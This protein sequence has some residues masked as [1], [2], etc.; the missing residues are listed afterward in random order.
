MRTLSGAEIA[1]LSGAL[2]RVTPR[3][4]VENGS[5]TM[6]DMTSWVERAA[7][8][9]DID[10]PVSGATIDFRRD[11]GTLSL[12][13]TRAD[14]LLNR[15]DAA[16]YAPL[17]DAGRA[18]TIEVATTALNTAPVAGDYKMLFSG[19]ADAVN[20]ER[21]P[22][23][24]SYRDLGGALVDSWL[25][26]PRKYG[27]T[28]G[29]P[30]QTVMAQVLNVGMGTGVVTLSTPV[31]PLYDILPIYEQQPMSVMQALQELAQLRG[32]DVRYKWDETTSSFKLTLLDPNR[33]KT[34]PDWTF[35]PSQ[36]LD[37]TNLVVDRTNVRNAIAGSYLD[38]S[39][40]SRK[41][42]TLEDA[43][44]IS[45]YGRKF[46]LIQEGD[47][48]PIKSTTKMTTMLTA[49]LADLK[50]PKAEQELLTHFFWPVELGDLYR[51]SPNS[52]HYNSNQDYAVVGFSHELT[53]T[54]HRTTIRTRGT[55]AG[56][57]F[58]WRGRT[59]GNTV[60]QPD[61]ANA[62]NNFRVIAETDT[63]VT[64][65]WTLG[66]QVS[67]VWAADILFD[68]PLPAD[69][70]DDVLNA[71]SPLPT[72]T[73]S[74]TYAK[75][76]EGQQRL[77]QVE[78]R[79]A[80]LT[81]GRVWRVTLNQASTQPPIVELDDSETDSI[82]TQFWKLIE[83]GLAVS[84]VTVQ[85]Q[86]G[87]EPIS[88][89]VLPTRGP[90]DVSVVR[91]GT[92][93]PGEYEHDIQL[94]P[95]RLSW[96][97]PKVTLENGQIMV[98][99]PFGFDRD[100]RPNLLFVERLDTV[101]RIIADSDTKSLRVFDTLGT[102]EYVLDG[103]SATIDVALPGTNGVTGLGSSA[104]STFRIEARSDPT[105]DV[106][107]NTLLATR[108]I[109]IGGATA[110][111]SGALWDTPGVT[112]A[113]P[114]VGTDDATITLKATAAPVGW[115]VRLTITIGP[116]FG[117][118]TSDETANVSPALSAPPTSSTAYT[119]NAGFTRATPAPD[120]QFI[121]MTVKADLLDGSSVVQ[122]TRTVAASWYSPA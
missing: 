77:I 39:S 93:G 79:D 58:N 87:S 32:W 109:V 48:S 50:D 73:L 40:Q 3:I 101:L 18:V 110:P 107:V 106:D 17:L 25:E 9:Q 64:Y 116:G 29:V 65:G 31:D 76:A 10:Q 24:V 120:T 103:L 47:T 23:S 68:L 69:A 95:S 59:P 82:G 97:M 67:E 56:A 60:P 43:T 100:K 42:I 30:L 112:V 104:S 89:F 78:P 1:V 70:W 27:S 85:T 16:N 49:A 57:Y 12:A 20:W 98:L 52:V 37:I 26:A 45:R 13:P 6:I 86:V 66:G 54:S 55:P 75:P 113:G 119:W 38:F 5:G 71:V 121:T 22:V 84:A 61:T 108:D 41:I 122:D 92:L 19:I 105:V 94:D 80:D 15:D 14:S 62:L 90:G 99:G 83:R 8:D 91:G 33:T 44:S 46:F 88:A 28:D 11:H 96:I 34:V 118:V 35:G 53:R 7:M 81:P 72:G 114:P 2:Y 51:H 102:W 4:K 117:D 111:P 63:T 21:S 74:L 115:T 36:Y